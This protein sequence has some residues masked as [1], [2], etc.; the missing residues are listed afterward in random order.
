[1]RRRGEEI[2][3]ELEEEACRTV[4]RVHRQAHYKHV[5]G[6]VQSIL[7]GYHNYDENVSKD[8]ENIPE[9]KQ[10][11]REITSLANVQK[12]GEVKVRRVGNVV[13]LPPEMIQHCFQV[14]EMFAVKLS[15]LLLCSATAW[16]GH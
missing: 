1:M 6:L 16:I 8:D 5:H 4:Q 7:S 9:E 12:H 13:H 2:F 15:S 3:E 11:E 14:L 10:H